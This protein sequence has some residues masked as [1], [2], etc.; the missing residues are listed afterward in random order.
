MRLSHTTRPSDRRQASARRH[1]LE[2]SLVRQSVGRAGGRASWHAPKRL[3]VVELDIGPRIAFLRLH[4]SAGIAEAAAVRHA[5]RKLFRQ[6]VE[7]IVI[8]LRDLHYVASVAVAAVAA[9]LCRAEAHR[10]RVRLAVASAAVRHVLTGSRLTRWIRVYPSAAAAMSG[11][12]SP[13]G[14][15]R[16]GR[17]QDRGGS[18]NRAGPTRRIPVHGEAQEPLSP[19]P[20]RIARRSAPKRLEALFSRTEA[21]GAVAAEVA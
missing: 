10:H 12:S 9:G 8:D 14:P 1:S 17:Q 19:V 16:P 4:G 11:G 20:V 2:T 5:L 15:A 21:A 3:L 18:E 13:T 7:R 6:G